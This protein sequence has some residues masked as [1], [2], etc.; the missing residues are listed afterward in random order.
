METRGLRENYYK[1]NLITMDDPN[2]IC[3][4]SE[5]KELSCNTI[6]LTESPEDLSFA[7]IKKIYWPTESGS[8]SEGQIVYACVYGSPEE[9]LGFPD[10]TIA[11]TSLCPKLQIDTEPT[12]MIWRGVYSPPYKRQ[13]LFSQEVTIRTADLPRWKP[14]VIIDR[15]TLDRS[16]E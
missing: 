1:S 10:D 6:V 3:E 5:V 14:K 16:D 7:R 15:R 11:S 12:P 4:E 8:I 13:V 9:Y 2:I